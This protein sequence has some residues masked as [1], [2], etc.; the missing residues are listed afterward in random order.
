MEELNPMQQPVADEMPQ[1]IVP[2]TNTE[3]TPMSDNASAEEA[4]EP[5]ANPTTEQIEQETEPDTDYSGMN[6]EELL[7]AFNELMQDEVQKIKNRVGRIRNQFTTLTKEIQ[8]ANYDAFIAG[9]GLKEDY[10][11]ITDAISTEFQKLYAI[12]RQRRQKFQD[13]LEAQK[14]KNL[15]FKQGI[16]EELRQLIDRDEENIKKT[17]DEFNVIQDKWKSIGDVPREK[18]NDLWQNYHF[19]IEQFFNKV[20][21]S[22]ELRMLDLKRNLEQKVQLCEQA[23]ELIVE[24][25]ITKAF[26]GLQELRDKWR[27]IGPVP[28][29]QNEDIWQRFCNAANKIDER[30]KE[31]YDQRKEEYDRNLL[32]KQALVEKADEL[33]Q[34]L[35]DNVKSWNETTDQLDELLKVWKTIGPVPRDVND[36]IWT[37][38]KSM[39]DNFYAE[40]KNFFGK[41]RDEQSENYNKKIDLCLKAEAI[42][43]RE[44]WK[45]ATAEL[46][47]LQ[48]EWKQTGAVSRKVSEKIW[49]RFRSAC[50]E[51]FA[52]KGEYFNNIHGSEQENLKLKEA[53]IT[54]L[55]EHQFGDNKEENLNAIKDFQRRWME[56]G[57]VPIAEKDRLQ[58]EFRGII[59]GYFEKLRITAR[60]AEETAY[61]ER[62][63]NIAG[64]SKKFVHGERQEIQEKIDKLK[65]D[66]NVWENN[67]GFLANSKQ[68]DLLKEE[69]EKKMQGARQQIALLQAKLRILNETEKNEAEQ[70]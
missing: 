19:L 60:E 43:K 31:Y 58:K 65:N 25:S 46:L 15:E 70:E 10:Q 38:F 59:D 37:K 21:I 14:Q 2:E 24:S 22:K 7:S 68:A 6:R 27:E 47:Q 55:K 66:L 41:L 23:E 51:F 50:D 52:K 29:E 20:K 40:K 56:I 11:E 49:H 61:R 36:E 35:P 30:R 3:N 39:I 44:D 67:L 28:T 5:T 33:T 63:R 62:I 64:D 26:K 69:F 16:L 18:V 54:E 34:T 53:I 57:F 1:N 12:F 42:A 17:Y 9:G 32:A 45:K 4:Q 48:E 8:K 13:D